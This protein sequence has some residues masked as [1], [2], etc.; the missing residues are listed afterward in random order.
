VEFFAEW[1]H[2][3]FDLKRLP[4]RTATHPG[5]KRIDEVMF[6]CRPATW[7]SSAALWPI[8]KDEIIR[9]PALSQNDGYN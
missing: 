7:K 9:N 3:W 5:E 8:P 2:R 4:A 1:G 6:S